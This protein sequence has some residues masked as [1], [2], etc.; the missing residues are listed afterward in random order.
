M[1]FLTIFLIAIGL[2][3]DSFAVSITS[4]LVLSRIDFKNAAKIAFS[5]GFF[6]ALMPTLGWLI[7]IKI[8]SYIESFDHWIAF[9][10]LFIIGIKMILE[11]LKSDENDKNFNPLNPKILLMIS[12]ATSI[13][14]LVVGIS[15][16]FIEYKWFLSGMII[17]ATTFIISM[18][19]IL[20]GKKMG[21]RFGNKMEILGG[22][23][24]IFLGTRILFQHLGYLG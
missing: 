2:S 21:S 8:Q 18:L 12:L 7:G 16:A 13:D 9:G 22:L 11:S 24:L 19:G 15:F 23:I 20:F 6:Q 14:A 10:L 5:L 3:M 4:G 17:G 1:E